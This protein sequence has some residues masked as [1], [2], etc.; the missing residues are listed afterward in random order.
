MNETPNPITV[1]SIDKILKFLPIFQQEGYKFSEWDSPKNFEDGVLCIPSCNYS[2]EVIEFEKTLYEEV[3]II[4]FEW[5]KWQD[6]AERLM[7][8]PN[9]LRTADLE[10]L[11]KLLTTHVRKERFC[12]GHLAA[13]LREHHITAILHRLKEIREEMSDSL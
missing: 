8:D 1:D 10:T 12:E 9:A 7:S 2:K 5:V 4:P 11:K 3:F 6:E 13:M